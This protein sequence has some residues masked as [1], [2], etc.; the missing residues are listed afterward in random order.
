MQMCACCACVAIYSS[1][2]FRIQASGMMEL[3]GGY[4]HSFV[5]LFLTELETVLGSELGGKASS[6]HTVKTDKKPL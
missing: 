5:Y 1:A 6:L 2:H 3:A 4:G